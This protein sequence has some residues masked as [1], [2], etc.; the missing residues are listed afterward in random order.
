MRAHH[1][2][3][4]CPGWRRASAW[5][6]PCAFNAATSESRSAPS[7]GASPA[8]IDIGDDDRI[9]IVEAGRE[10]VEQ[11]LQARVA[12]RLHDGDDLRLGRGARGA[13]HRSDLDRMMAVIV[14]D[15][16]RPSIRRSGEAALDAA[17]AR[18]RAADRVDAHAELM[19]DGDRRGGIERI[20]MAG[21]RQ[22]EIFRVASRRPSCGR[23]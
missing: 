23:G 17:K 18:E 7:I 3:Q 13:Q 5:R 20:V 21:H 10:F 9:G 16:R 22:A 8:G 11:R 19:R 14:E 12:M 1:L 2:R 6:W 4:I 15:A